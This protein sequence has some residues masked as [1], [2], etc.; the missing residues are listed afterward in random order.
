MLQGLAERMQ[1]QVKPTQRQI[2]M[3]AQMRKSQR[4]RMTKRKTGKAETE[5]LVV[6]LE[7]LTVHHWPDRATMTRDLT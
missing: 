7:A 5:Q 6:M 2:I 4:K 3:R 1:R